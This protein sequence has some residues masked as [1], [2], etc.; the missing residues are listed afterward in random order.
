MSEDHDDD[1]A[2]LAKW[3]KIMAM[4]CVRNTKLE[5]IHAGLAPIT[6]TGDYS[7]VVVVDADGT[8]IPWNRVSR[9]DDDTMRDLMRQIVDRL[10]TF[11]VKADDPRFLAVIGPWAREAVRWDEPRLDPD[12]MYGFDHTPGSGT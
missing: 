10:Y 7:D 3:V 8:R 2:V 12:L 6:R 11:H 9:F 5:D 4:T 1:D